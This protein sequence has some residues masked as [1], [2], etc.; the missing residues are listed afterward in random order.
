[1]ILLVPN[2]ANKED[3]IE[4]LRDNG[5]NISLD[6]LILDLDENTTNSLV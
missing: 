6:E 4:K 5:T 3:E 1:M 2:N